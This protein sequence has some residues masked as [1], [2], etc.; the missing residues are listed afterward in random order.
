MSGIFE[1]VDVSKGGI[2][3]FI[4]LIR[5][6]IGYESPLFARGLVAW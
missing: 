1:Y 3:N 6:S 4:G 2:V 5:V